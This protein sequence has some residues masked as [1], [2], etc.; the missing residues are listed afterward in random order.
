MST[1]PAQRLLVTLSQ[2]SQRQQQDISREEIRKKVQEIKYLSA[3]KKIPQLTLRKELIHLEHRLERVWGLEAQLHR[4]QKRENLRV[5]NHHRQVAA[6][7]KKLAAAQDK[8]LQNKVERL[9]HL[10]GEC[11]AK[12]TVRQEV[13]AYTQAQEVQAR[14]REEKS[15]ILELQKKVVLVHHQ[16]QV[17]EELQQLPPEQLEQMRM[18]LQGMEEKLKEYSLPFPEVSLPERP[19]IKHEVMFAEPQEDF[20]V[21]VEKELPLPPPPKVKMRN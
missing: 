8:D 12:H 21:G 4:Q 20:S 15:R 3:Q 18:R 2:L 7:K 17:T 5:A 13:T 6:L 11:L 10:L 9:S 19:A 16:L 14:Q 1:F